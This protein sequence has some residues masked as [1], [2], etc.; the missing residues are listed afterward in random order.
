MAIVMIMDFPATAAQY[1][2][3]N[4]AMGAVDD[5]PAGLILHAASERE[6]GMRV[7]DVWESQEDFDRFREERLNP[8]V[9]EVMGPQAAEAPVPGPEVSE[10]YNLITP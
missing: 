5:P 9:S 6:G 1:D 8:A 7:V 2:Q 3:V 10:V 4:A